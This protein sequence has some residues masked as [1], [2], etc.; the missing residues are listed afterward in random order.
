MEE[1][2]NVMC[3]YCGTTYAVE[4]D[5]SEGGQQTFIVDCENCCRPARITVAW[6]GGQVSD[7]QVLSEVD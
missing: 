1:F 6:S 7:L 2:V 3:P 4:V 5:P